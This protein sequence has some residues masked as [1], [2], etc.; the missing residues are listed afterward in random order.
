MLL[1]T[2]FF[3]ALFLSLESFSAQSNGR[4]L[5][6]YRDR[7]LTSIINL[8]EQQ[9]TSPDII[10]L[11]LDANATL[12]NMPHEVHP[13]RLQILTDNLYVT[14]ALDTRPTITDASTNIA[15]RYDY[16]FCK[17]RDENF[18]FSVNNIQQIRLP[19]CRIEFG[20]PIGDSECTVLNGDGILAHVQSRFSDHAP[21]ISKVKFGSNCVL[22]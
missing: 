10:I 8:I 17:C 13:E 12:A 21:V 2:C 15:R 19:E 5:C 16:V 14:D 11:G 3:L 4:E 9:T 1:Y 20:F 6:I 7:E 22:F 18:V